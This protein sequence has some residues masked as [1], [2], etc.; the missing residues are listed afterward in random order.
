MKPQFI[1]C[2]T[3]ILA[4]VAVLLAG[5][6]WAGCGKWVIRDNTDFLTDPI[7]DEAVA[8]STGSSATANSD[9]SAVDSGSRE[10]KNAT[11]STDAA[12]NGGETA[13]SATLAEQAIPD[14]NGKWSV[15]LEAGGAKKA[16]DLILI[17]NKDRLQG[18]GTLEEGS[19]D[20]PATA[21][22]S[23]SDEAVSLIVKVSQSKKDYHLEMALADDDMQG[24]YELFSEQDLA[25]SGNATA[26]RSNN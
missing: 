22:G 21:T 14:I 23:V 16:I 3:S 20:T 26:S 7:F 15:T 4:L 1:I 9:G 19:S 5:P 10:K 13:G 6:A 11:E 8:S 25:E 2:V 24:S 18:Y 17:Q 12:P